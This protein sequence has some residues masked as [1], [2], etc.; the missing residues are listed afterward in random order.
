MG[1]DRLAGNA[2]R[3]F[4]MARTFGSENIDQ[5][6]R[7]GRRVMVGWTGP[8]SIASLAIPWNAQSLPRDLSLG[9]DRS[10][11]QRF[12]PE[13]K[14]LRTKKVTGRVADV[15]LQ[16][17]VYASFRARSTSQDFGV[18]VLKDVNDG[19]NHTRISLS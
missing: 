5:V 16:A 1:V 10:L 14:I 2:S 9:P 6:T 11:R 15:G 4:S 17:E 7:A 13:L 8:G 18:I 19:N 12:V 3:G